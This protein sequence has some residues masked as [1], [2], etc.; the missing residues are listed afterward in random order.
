MLAIA[1]LF[2]TALPAATACCVGNA[3]KTESMHA[4]PCCAGSCT[5]SKPNVSR[6]DNVTLIPAP[7]PQPA[8]TA[9][10]TL[11]PATPAMCASSDI[12]A[13]GNG[14]EFSPPPSF[15]ANAQFRI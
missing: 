9:I 3:G 15:L 2:V 11:I 14:A 10:A 1:V 6:D 4:M 13:A 12:R 5:M 7:S 8:T